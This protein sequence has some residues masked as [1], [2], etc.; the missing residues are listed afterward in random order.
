MKEISS[1]VKKMSDCGHCNKSFGATALVV[2]C[3]KCSNE[4]HGTCL[5]VNKTLFNSVQQSS[6]VFILCNDCS[7]LFNSF[8]SGTTDSHNETSSQTTA[9][10][11]SAHLQR[12]ED[13][14]RKNHEMIEK[15]GD[16]I[17][18]KKKTENDYV[19]SQ[20][21]QQYRNV[22]P[23]KKYSD[24][25]IGNA[26]ASSDDVE[27]VAVEPKKWIFVSRIDAATDDE[28]F[29]KFVSN[30][31]IDDAVC[32]RMTPKFRDNMQ[33]PYISYKIGVSSTDFKGLMEPSFWPKGLLVKEFE[34]RYRRPVNFPVDSSRQ[35]Q[36]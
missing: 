12:L 16:Y 33:P 19:L 34:M 28:T 11:D 6:N 29:K 2:K 17:F 27:I 21:Q 23:S 26:V 5:G 30:K 22:V 9:V 3:E 25:V 24:V 36:K 7:S 1:T 20:Q 14:I 10:S 35:P 13:Q 18:N 32:I 15:I 4:F 8:L 31:G